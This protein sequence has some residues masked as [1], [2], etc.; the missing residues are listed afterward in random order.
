VSTIGEL[1]ANILSGI[2]HEPPKTVQDRRARAKK[3]R[4]RIVASPS[5]CLGAGG[6]T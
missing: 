4:Q 1:R 2:G 5:D 6:G 3:G